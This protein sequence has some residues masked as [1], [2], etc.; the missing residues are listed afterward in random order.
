MENGS[1]SSILT[2]AE[3]LDAIDFWKQQKEEPEKPL[4]QVLEEKEQGM[5]PSTQDKT[6]ITLQVEE[7]EVMH[8]FLPAKRFEI[9]PMIEKNR[10]VD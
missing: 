1:L 10:V 5:A 8:R 3:T 6:T 9:L 2:S 7:L 4:H